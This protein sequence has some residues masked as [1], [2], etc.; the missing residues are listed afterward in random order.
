MRDPTQINRKRAA[1][2]GESTQQAMGPS[3]FKECLGVCHSPGFR[4]LLRPRL[5]SVRRRRRPDR[6]GVVFKAEDQALLALASMVRAPA[7]AVISTLRGLACSATGMVTV[8]T[9]L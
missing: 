9:P 8:R 5:S 1:A 4:H 3:R 7:S 6:A 2:W